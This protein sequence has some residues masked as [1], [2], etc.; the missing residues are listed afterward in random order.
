MPGT[1]RQKS[2]S[3]AEIA[4]GPQAHSATLAFAPLLVLFMHPSASPSSFC[5]SAKTIGPSTPWPGITSF[6][7]TSSLISTG[8]YYRIPEAGWLKQQFFFLTV[9]ETGNSRS[10]RHH[11]LVLGEGLVPSLQ[12]AVFS[13]YPHIAE[14]RERN[15][16]QAPFCLL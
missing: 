8:Y 7:K 12:L 9:L 11:G 5:P 16:K 15:K 3:Y 10:R 13:L 6:V 4:A 14:G 1:A 2:N